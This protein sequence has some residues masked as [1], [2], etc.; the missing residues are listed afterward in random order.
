MRRPTTPLPLASPPPPPS[1]PN[2]FCTP[3]SNI[4]PN[5]PNSVVAALPRSRK[6]PSPPR[7]PRACPRSLCSVSPASCASSGTLSEPSRAPALA[8]K[9]RPRSVLETLSTSASASRAAPARQ[10]AGVVHLVRLERGEARAS[11]RRRGGPADGALEEQRGLDRARVGVVR[12][13]RVRVV[14]AQQAQARRR[15]ERRGRDAGQRE[16]GVRV[17]ERVAERASDG[18]VAIPPGSAKSRDA[19]RSASPSAAMTRRESSGASAALAKSTARCSRQRGS[20]ARAS[21]A[22]ISLLTKVS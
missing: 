2:T 1:S 11:R 7:P 5:P 14:G 8:R 16:R 20:N 18:S 17:R 10:E 12:A 13:R 4:L 6:P 21:S 22:R 15:V 9:S 3:L 19:A